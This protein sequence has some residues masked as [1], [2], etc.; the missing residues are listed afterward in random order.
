MEKLLVILLF[1]TGILI[2]IF[3]QPVGPLAV[4]F[5]TFCAGI[6][7]FLINKNFEGEERQ[8]LRKL[9]IVRLL[10]RIGLATAT[11]IFDLLGQIRLSNWVR[12]RI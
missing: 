11:Y 2:T 9:F 1:V 12:R 6:A 10:L 3:V 8:F 5:G 4:L 7:V